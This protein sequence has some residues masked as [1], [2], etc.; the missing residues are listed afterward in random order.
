MDDFDMLIET[1]EFYE[2]ESNRLI[3]KLKK[4]STKKQKIS[5]L[6]ELNSLKQKIKFEINQINRI[7]EENEGY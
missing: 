4:C 2:K 5:V 3:S 7:I 6:A 1:A